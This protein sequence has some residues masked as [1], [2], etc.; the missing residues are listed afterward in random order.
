MSLRQ[1]WVDEL[2]YE[3]ARWPLWRWDL[4]LRYLAKSLL[5]VPRPHAATDRDYWE[6]WRRWMP[7]ALERAPAE[8]SVAAVGDLMWLRQGYADFLMPE[9]ATLLRG[10]GALIGN[11]E[12]PVDPTRPVKRWVYET[13]RYNAPSAYLDAVADLGLAAVVLSLGNNH[14]LDQGAGGLARTR[15]EVR[16][17]GFGCLGGAGALEEAVAVV[18][19]GGARVA[20]F[21]T[22]FGLNHDQE[23]APVGVP[24]VA[25]GDARRATDWVAIERLIAIAR[26]HQPD[27]IVAVPHWG[28]EYE[29][30]PDA[31]MR[32]AAARLVE[33]GVDAVLGSSPHVLQP[34]DV[35]S[36]DGWDARAPTQVSRGGPPRAAVVAY[37][38]GN[39]ASVMPTAACRIG[40]VLELG[41]ERDGGAVSLLPRAFHPT[42]TLHGRRG[43]PLA[44]ATALLDGPALNRQAHHGL[45]TLPKRTHR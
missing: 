30:W 45:R 31:A 2:R 22:T 25:F 9:V 24:V 12:T 39:F 21:A 34:V 29:Y 4:N 36:I 15:A 20:C 8:T 32:A 11:L 42:F 43:N 6:R 14:A 37:S 19:I 26:A 1:A 5:H 7:A 44:T 35:F 3:S 10:A 41:I 17:R 16:D 33:L 28:F 27:L 23:R 18:S 13:L 38:L 40:G